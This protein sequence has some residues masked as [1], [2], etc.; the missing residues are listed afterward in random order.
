MVERRQVVDLL[1]SSWRY[2]R[3]SCAAR[4]PFPFPVRNVPAV[5]TLFD[6]FGTVKLDISLLT[7]PLVGEQHLDRLARAEC[8]W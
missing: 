4:Q 5:Y 1:R 3:N 2:Y 8:P 6:A 7:E